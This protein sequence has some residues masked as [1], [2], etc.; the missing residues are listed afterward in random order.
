MDLPDSALPGTFCWVDLAATDA[1][2]AMAFYA[3]AFG[4]TFETQRANGGQFTRCRVGGRDVA[5]LYALSGTQRERGVPSHWT[6]YLRVDD[7]DALVPRIT[8]QGG[9]L[10]VAPFEVDGVA[11]I[12][13]VEDTVGALL[14]LW[15]PLETGQLGTIRP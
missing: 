14:G 2:R 12:A 11:R 9:R 4:W 15:Q 8:A 10:L 6:P 7:L 1:A 3:Q 13:L 5:T